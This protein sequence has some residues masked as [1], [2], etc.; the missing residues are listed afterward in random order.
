[1]LLLDLLEHGANVVHVAHV[2]SQSARTDARFGHLAHGMLGVGLTTDVVDDYLC[3]LASQLLRDRSAN[4]A[5][6]AGNQR[7]LAFKG[8]LIHG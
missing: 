8:S 4:A 1:M 5:A 3:A 6:A 7:N 2:A